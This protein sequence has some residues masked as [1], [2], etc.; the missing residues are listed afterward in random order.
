MNL[1]RLDF[2]SWY[3]V[4]LLLALAGAGG[5]AKAA[6]HGEIAYVSNEDSNDLT[7]IATDDNTV[8]ETIPVGKRPR[9]VRVSPDGKTV[10]VALSGSP[11][12]PPTMPDEECEKLVADKSAD[13]VAEVDATTR[14]IRRILPGGSDP[15]TFDVN[16]RTGK[17]YVSN[18]DTNQT[19]I[20]DLA[21]G[22]VEATLAVGREPE[23]VRL[24]PDGKLCYVTGETDHDITVID[25]TTGTVTGRIPV[26]KRPRDAVF[27]SDGSR[28]YV[29]SELDA[30]VSIIDVAAGKV[31]GTID[32]PPDSKPMGVA[33]SPDDRTLYV[34]TGRGKLV[35][36]VDLKTNTVTKS[37]EVGQRPWGIALG[38][39]G[40]RLYTANGP[41]NDV[42][43][44]DTA[45]M[46]VIGRVPAGKS[47]W[48][49]AIGRA[50][51]K[52]D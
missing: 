18:E 41:S 19:T 25:T 2:S 17:L 51:A 52:A 50:P 13:G 16:W 29:S 14:K 33:V 3:R 49:V 35:V 9:G 34:A 1:S 24:S 45:T 22:T 6:T 30:K 28:A 39:N 31:I 32:L 8:I 44:V 15:E 23:G 48:G 21:S 27:L 26:G 10:Y 20:I 7:V 12:C 46:T 5:C 40:T 43:V 42:T 4:G 47:P 37:V 38:A 11:K 36:A